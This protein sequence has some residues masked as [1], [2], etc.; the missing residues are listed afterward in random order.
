MVG[1]D[2]PPRNL[3]GARWRLSAHYRIDSRATAR[4][5]QKFVAR[6]GEACH[7]SPVRGQMSAARTR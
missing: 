7:E 5:S 2:S 6:G 3:L 1:E 4:G